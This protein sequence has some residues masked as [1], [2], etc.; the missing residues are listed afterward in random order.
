[1]S[2]E[3]RLTELKLEL[4]TAP[5]PVAVYR[6]VVVAGN[7]AYVSGHGPLKA[8]GTMIAGR[9]GADLDLAAGKAAARQ[10]G[11]AIL[12]SLRAHLGSLDRVKRLVKLLGMVNATPDFRDHPA[13]INGCS[14]L[15]AEVFG[16]ENGIGARSAVGMGSLPGNIAVE[17]EAIFELE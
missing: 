4:P 6:T 13:V 11:L 10:T 9:V 17:I 16:P 12:A 8:D 14:E 2:A 1:M 15:F 7:V 5:K 3:K